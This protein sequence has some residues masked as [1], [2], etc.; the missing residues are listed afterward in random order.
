MVGTVHPEIL[1]YTAGRDIELDPELLEVDCLG[2]MAHA[3][4]L[5]QMGLEKPI[6]T[7]EDAD[8]I[9]EALLGIIREGRE[10][11]IDI[12]VED[13]DVHLAVERHLT[14]RLGDL[15]KR[16][17]T[18]RSRN[19]Q[20]ALD[21]RLYGRDRLLETGEDALELTDVL[22]QFAREHEQVPMVGRTHMQP[23]MPSSVGLWASSWAESLLEDLESLQTVY[24]V[25]NRCPLGSAA[26]YGVPLPINRHAV[27]DA[28]GFS[29][30][31]QNV[32][33]VGST[34]GKLEF[35]TLSALHHVMITLSRLAQDLMLF[36][37]PEFGYFSLSPECCTGSSIMPQKQNP[38]PLEI[39]RARAARLSADVS[40][41]ADILRALPSGYNRDVQETKELYMNGF[42][43]VR[44]SVRVM[45]RIMKGCI[46]HE[47]KLREAFDGTVFAT[48]Q[49]LKHVAE[50]MS[51]RDAYYRVKD[52]LTDLDAM[53]PAEALAD[54]THY[55]AA[56]GLDWSHYEHA[57]ATLRDWILERRNSQHQALEKLLGVPY[58]EL[59]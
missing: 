23:A 11:H 38:D 52:H 10:G 33:H 58:P 13:Q 21:L 43:T 27:S 54:K 4:M 12:T 51:W 42:E 17:H 46:V 32:I 55:G 14:E 31:L 19:D 29:R 30:P 18:G 34:R 28:L 9:Q 56:A 44:M 41:A 45:I 7:K 57:V 24:E 6:L 5:S 47:K 26:G 49:A 48:D 1:A 35:S 36:T 25:T 50:G 16:I 53:D 3:R 2:S 37:M 8:R 59:S 15:G 40:A 20:V 22:L 39:L